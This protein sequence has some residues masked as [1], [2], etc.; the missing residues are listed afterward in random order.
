MPGCTIVSLSCVTLSTRP[1][2]GAVTF[3]RSGGAPAPPSRYRASRA[4]AC[5]ISCSAA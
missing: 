1:E 3:Q 2:T 5:S 4:F